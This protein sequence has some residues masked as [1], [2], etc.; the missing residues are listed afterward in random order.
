MVSMKADQESF[1]MVLNEARRGRFFRN[2]D[3]RWRA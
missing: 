2:N 3:A 1:G